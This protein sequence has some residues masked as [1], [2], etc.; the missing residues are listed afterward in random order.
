MT[1]IKSMVELIG[2]EIRD[3]VDSDVTVAT[4]RR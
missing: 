2:T 4:V 1:P 3:K